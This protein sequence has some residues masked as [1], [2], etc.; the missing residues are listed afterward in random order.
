MPWMS[1]LFALLDAGMST[2]DTCLPDF[3]YC[4][5]AAVF[6]GSDASKVQEGAQRM[7]GEFRKRWVG[8]HVGP[9]SCARHK[10]CRM[11]QVLFQSHV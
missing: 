6:G 5:A 4:G 2:F 9:F 10:S 11:D 7:L 1:H 3:P 8:L